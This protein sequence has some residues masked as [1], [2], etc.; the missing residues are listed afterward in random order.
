MK[1]NEALNAIKAFS[2][3]A[4]KATR[5]AVRDGIV[6]GK[7]VVNDR[8]LL[9]QM[10]IK[11]GIGAGIGAAAG[12]GTSYAT[13]DRHAVRDG[14]V[15]GV[16]GGLIGAG[17]AGGGPISRKLKGVLNPGSMHGPDRRVFEETHL[18]HGPWNGGTPVGTSG[19]TWSGESDG[20]AS[21]SPF[22]GKSPSSGSGSFSSSYQTR[23]Q[24]PVTTFKQRKLKAWQDSRLPTSFRR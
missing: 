17:W 22:E 7:Q 11:G 6:V 13:G 4:S 2:V 19:R 12:V 10:A 9:R 8:T 14:V 21:Y 20:V 23:G 3:Q 16:A 15:G 24:A 1:A 5:S 18:D